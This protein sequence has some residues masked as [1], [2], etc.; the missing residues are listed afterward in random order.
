MSK[1]V[2]FLPVRYSGL[3]QLVEHLTVNQAVGGSNPSPGGIGSNPIWYLLMEGVR[4]VEGAVLKTVGCK[5]LGGSIP[6]PSDT[7][8]HGVVV[9]REASVLEFRVRVLWVCK[10]KTNT[11]NSFR[12]EI[13]G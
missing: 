6:S 9:T 8:T 10:N 7:K 2:I 11:I 1:E 12:E 4:L 5:S 3:A 13:R